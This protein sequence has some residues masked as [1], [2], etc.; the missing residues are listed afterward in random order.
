MASGLD[1]YKT[2]SSELK[3][4]AFQKKGANIPDGRHK[5][6]VTGL[7]SNE[8]SKGDLIRIDLSVV[9]SVVDGAKMTRE[10]QGKACEVVYFLPGDNPEKAQAALERFFRDLK[11]I[12]GKI[13]EGELSE[14]TFK[15]WAKDAVGMVVYAKKQTNP[16]PSKPDEPYI[17][18]YINEQ[19]KLS[20]EDLKA[21]KATAP[22][23]PGADGATTATAA[24]ATTPASPTADLDELP[25]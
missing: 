17:N 9:S 12:F 24:A 10:H 1:K 21:L 4:G 8:T 2:K 19:A 13:P 15:A 22:A 5:L 23:T 7:S 20:D 6:R 25:F 3:A 11:S 18:F 14:E 16:N